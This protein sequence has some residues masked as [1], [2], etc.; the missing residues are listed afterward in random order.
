MAAGRTM[1]T[2]SARRVGE[3]EARPVLLDSPALV[4]LGGVDGHR[5]EDLMAVDAVGTVLVDRFGA[6]LVIEQ[7]HQV[8]RAPADKGPYRLETAAR[9]VVALSA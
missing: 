7:D 6:R 3:D 5:D 4:R 9:W 1:V 2:G 8:V